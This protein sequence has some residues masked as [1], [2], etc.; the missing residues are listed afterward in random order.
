M[1]FDLGPSRV[2][3][4]VLLNS[5][6]EETYMAHYL[7]LTPR[8]NELYVSP[9]RNDKN[10]TAAFYRGIGGSLKF[11]DFGDGTCEDFV[12]VVQ[13]LFKCSY[14]R[15][16]EIVANDFGIVK[17]P[18][19][20]VNAPKAQADGTVTNEESVVTV[21]QCKIREF[22]EEDLKWWGDQGIGHNTLIKFNVHAVEHVY[23]N[24]FLHTSDS[25]MNPIYGYYFGMKDGIEQWKIYFPKRKK[26]RFLL[27]T[28]QV[29][30]WKHLPKDGEL[31]VITKSYKEVMA[32][33]ELGIPAIA[34]QTEAVVLDNR[35]IH[36]LKKRFKI[37]VTNGDYDRAGQI[38]MA[39]SRRAY[40]TICLTF[41][42]KDL[43]GKDIT[44]FIEKH[45]IEKA[46]KL[47]DR[48]L[49]WIKDGVFDYQYK[50]FKESE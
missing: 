49:K 44:E 32:L 24:G 11:K 39:K 38:L 41:T 7:G 1:L 22:T 5:N 42:N 9:L 43:Y 15:A 13:L 4:E 18:H 2:T 17:K 26:Y 12:G 45:G 16:L 29:Q 10:P 48:V 30:G 33:H 27:N 35:Y 8:D 36:H 37:I 34:A 46:R 50:Y 31:L 47:K 3:K 20:A 23:L 25:K 40:K 6:S 19:L 28:N 14:P 21:I